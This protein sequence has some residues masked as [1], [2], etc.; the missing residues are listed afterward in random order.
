[1]LLCAGA[2]VMSSCDKDTEG[3]TWITY[4][5]SIEILGDDPAVIN[6]GETYVDQGCT[7]EMNGEDV[8]DR[9]S[10][11]SE[12]NSNEVGSYSINY[13]VYNDDGFSASASRTVYVV[14]PTSIATIYMSEV[15]NSSGRYHYYNAPIII[16]DNGDGTYLVDDILGGFCFY[17]YYAGYEPSYDFHAEANIAIADDGTVTLVGEV[18]NWYGKTGWGYDTVINSGTYDAATKT[19]D[20]SVSVV[21]WVDLTMTFVAVTKD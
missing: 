4:Y 1:M 3:M 6:L 11:D 7:A 14:N 19:F 21:G 10:V 16:S 18:G 5:P 12:V 8:S 17:G 2:F 20:L 13:I 15:Q 9:I